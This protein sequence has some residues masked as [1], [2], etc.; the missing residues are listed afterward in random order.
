MEFQSGGILRKSLPLPEDLL[1]NASPSVFAKQNYS[2]LSGW[3]VANLWKG[4]SPLKGPSSH[5]KT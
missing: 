1:L 2:Y 4:I 5:T 3:W